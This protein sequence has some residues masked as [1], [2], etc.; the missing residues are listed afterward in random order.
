MAFIVMGLQERFFL[1]Q[2]RPQRR[3]QVVFQNP[4]AFQPF[5]NLSRKPKD[6]DNF[7]FHF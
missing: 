1:K 7:A 2:E 4:L 3:N 5:Q 6:V